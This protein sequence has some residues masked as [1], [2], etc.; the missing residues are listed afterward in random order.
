[1][2]GSALP[3]SQYQDPE[4]QITR[5]QAVVIYRRDGCSAC[6]SFDANRRGGSCKKNA[7]PGRFW[8]KGFE[9]A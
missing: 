6:L 7:L 8:C 3:S 4:K 5:E 1:M 9:E 2:D